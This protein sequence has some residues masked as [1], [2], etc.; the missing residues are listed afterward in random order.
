[1]KNLPNLMKALEKKIKIVKK[2]NAGQIKAP[3]S[4]NGRVMIFMTIESQVSK[5]KTGRPP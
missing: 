3:R 4:S 1:M 5:E 2:L